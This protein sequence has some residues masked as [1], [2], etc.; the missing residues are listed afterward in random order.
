MN[1][2]G[3]EVVSKPLCNWNIYDVVDF[4]YENGIY[5]NNEN[6]WQVA[7]DMRSVSVELKG[8]LDRTIDEQM[9]EKNTEI[10]NYEAMKEGFSIRA[11]DLESQIAAL[12]S[13]VS[14]LESLQGE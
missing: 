5:L 14:E 4:L 1:G 2:I 13:K 12:T 9:Q 8:I 11:A 10:S 3:I 7:Q 6:W